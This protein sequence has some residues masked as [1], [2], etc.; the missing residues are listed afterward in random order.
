MSTAAAHVSRKPASVKTTL[1]DFIKDNNDVILAR[2][3]KRVANRPA[4]SLHEVERGL[5]L[6]LTQLSETLRLE[7][8]DTPFPTSAMGIAAA[9][10]GKELVEGGYSVSQVVHDYG[11]I[12]QAITELALEHKAPITVKEFHTLNRCLDLAIAEAVTEHAR[13]MTLQ[14]TSR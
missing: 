10:H 6:F 4:A 1:Y 12:C 13:V 7:T 8:S 14:R 3:I 11:D 5:P 9:A 2:T